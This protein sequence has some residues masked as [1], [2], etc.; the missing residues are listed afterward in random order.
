VSRDWNRVP[1][2]DEAALIEYCRTG[3]AATY[4]QAVSC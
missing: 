2:A 3:I 4:A 1:M